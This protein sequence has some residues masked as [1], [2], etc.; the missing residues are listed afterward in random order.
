MSDPIH[1]SEPLESLE[2]RRDQFDHLP[3]HIEVI[4]SE[5]ESI[6]ATLLRIENQR[7]E[8]EEARLILQKFVESIDFGIYNGVSPTT[9]AIISVRNAVWILCLIGTAILLKLFMK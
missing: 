1:Y 8:H 7:F 9:R 5:L 2:R 6:H 3:I 4:R